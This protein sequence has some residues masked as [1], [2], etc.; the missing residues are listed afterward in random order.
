VPNG[1]EVAIAMS[2][3]A[4]GMCIGVVVIVL[5]ALMQQ[6]M[7]SATTAMPVG[8][9]NTYTYTGKSGLLS[10]RFSK[11]SMEQ[12]I[13]MLITNGWESRES[14]RA[15]RTRASGSDTDGS[16]SYRRRQSSRRRK[17]YRGSSHHN[18][19]PYQLSDF[20][21]PSWLSV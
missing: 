17:P 1:E 11:M 9:V 7:K 6:G 10:E 4:I 20:A 13:N 15:A 3:V 19:P 16:R 18:L 12:H 2:F 5:K 8:T 21:H 14:D